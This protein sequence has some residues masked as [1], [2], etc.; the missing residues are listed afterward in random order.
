MQSVVL[1][2]ILLKMLIWIHCGKVAELNTDIWGVCRTVEALQDVLV[3]YELCLSQN[4][5]IT[6][7]LSGLKH[8]IV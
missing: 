2:L 7:I 3:F 8:M 1:H 6:V 5:L 4:C